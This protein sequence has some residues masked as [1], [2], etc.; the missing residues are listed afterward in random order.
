MKNVWKGLIIGGL[1]GMAGGIL[2]D[3]L[4]RGAH[5]VSALGARVAQEAPGVAGHLRDSVTD[6]VTETA[7]KVRDS[8]IPDHVREVSGAAIR[9][10]NKAAVDGKKKAHEGSS[11]L[12]SKVYAVGE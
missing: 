3:G 4:D 6:A 10:A 2:L 7:G 1:T 5:G 9:K 8:E 11:H 12:R